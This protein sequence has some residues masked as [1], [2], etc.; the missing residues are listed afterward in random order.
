MNNSQKV[1]LIESKRSRLCT[2]PTLKSI[3]LANGGKSNLIFPWTDGTFLK[4]STPSF[5]AVLTTFKCDKNNSLA[6][7]SFLGPFARSFLDK[8]RILE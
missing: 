4:I 5:N 8:L 1:R 3:S 6:G 2:I 7:M